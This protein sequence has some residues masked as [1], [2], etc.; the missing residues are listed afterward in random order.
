M[1]ESTSDIR[2][3]RALFD[4]NLCFSFVLCYC[5]GLV[6]YEIVELRSPEMKEV[7]YVYS[8]YL[9]NLLRMWN[10]AITPSCAVQ[11]KV[12]RVRTEIGHDIILD[13]T[14]KYIR[15]ISTYSITS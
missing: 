12:T 8:D 9:N 11:G 1:E 2:D 3:S 10:G 13:R 4:V 14:F 15:L 7:Y 6:K 5:S